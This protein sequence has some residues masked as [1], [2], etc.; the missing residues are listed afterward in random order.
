[1]AMALA[2]P[3]IQVATIMVATVVVAI[4]IAIKVIPVAKEATAT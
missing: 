1:M 2:A 4:T 3:I